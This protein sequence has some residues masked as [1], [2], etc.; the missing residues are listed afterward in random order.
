MR[1]PARRTS[2]HVLPTV[3][4]FWA[5]GRYY[6]DA[7]AQLR[8]DCR[9]LGLA[10]DIEAL[11]VPPSGLGRHLP[12]QGRL[13][14]AQARPS[15]PGRCCGSTST[16]ASSARPRCSTTA[17]S[18]SWASRSGSATSATTTPTNA[19]ASGFRASCS[20][21]TRRR[22]RVRRAH[23][24]DRARVAERITDDYCCR[25]R[26]RRSTASS[27]SGLLARDGRAD[28]AARPETVFVYGASGNV[29]EYRGSVRQHTGAWRSPGARERAGACAADLME[30]GEC[31]PR[32]ADAPGRRVDPA[33]PKATR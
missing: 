31:G 10:H 26:G 9:R 2:N 22:A 27:T 17:A 12:D 3:I 5:G 28:D 6:R 16:P 14:R 11:E 32:R 8:S 24:R 30:S 29:P 13:L 7:A 4:S 25:R 18:T 33:D 21:T 15:T 20:S 1:R 19:P 23:E